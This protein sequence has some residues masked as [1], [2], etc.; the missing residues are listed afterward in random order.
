MVVNDVS[1]TLVLALDSR[2]E[3][4]TT[5]L[6]IEP[7]YWAR[8]VHEGRGP[9][10]TKGFMRFFPNKRDD[11]RTAFGID[12]P[13]QGRKRRPLTRAEI[14]FFRKENRLREKLGVD[15]IMVEVRH[16]GSGP[17]GNQGP[18][19]KQFYVEALRIFPP[20]LAVEARFAEVMR[21]I[22][23]TGSVTARVRLRA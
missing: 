5:G 4:P 20:V 23:P 18:P 17:A 3:S 12:Y 21:K 9:V 10:D 14:S 15:P 22:A 16:V 13:G 11:P 6:L 7:Y 2:V 1:Q 8:F 19:G